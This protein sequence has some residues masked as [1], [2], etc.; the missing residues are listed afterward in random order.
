MA[1]PEAYEANALIESKL[2]ECAEALEDKLDADVLAF[3][4]DILHNADLFIREAI[5]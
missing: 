2:N 5:E 3:S 4:G 1:E